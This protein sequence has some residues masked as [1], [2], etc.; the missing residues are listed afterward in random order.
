MRCT[1]ECMRIYRPG[2]AR[3]VD[4]SLGVSSFDASLMPIHDFWGDE[5][6]SRALS[7]EGKV[8][9]LTSTLIQSRNERSHSS[10]G[11][12]LTLS[13]D[14]HADHTRREN[15]DD[16][17]QYWKFCHWEYV[18]PTFKNKLTV[19]YPMPGHSAISGKMFNAPYPTTTRFRQ[20]CD[21]GDLSSC[22][23]RADI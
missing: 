5:Y 17:N 19:S 23:A 1:T 6:V 2:S 4:F 11:I 3:H 9:H 20:E 15:T 10:T 22:V 18:C 13:L 14:L 21:P 8:L 16:T 7:G 12:H